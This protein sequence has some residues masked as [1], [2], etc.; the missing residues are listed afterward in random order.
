MSATNSRRLLMLIVVMAMAAALVVAGCGGSG[1]TTSAEQSPPSNETPE[2]EAVEGETESGPEEGEG[3]SEGGME[4][5][6]S[7]EGG[8]E[9]EAGGGGAAAEGKEV[10]AANCGSCHTLAAAGTSGNIGPNLDELMPD[11]S[12]VEMQVEN[13]GGAMPAFGKEGILSPEEV[14]AVSA[15]VS[16]EAGR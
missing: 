2:S 16:S 13:G 9:A 6:E 15:Y 12:T 14:K 10:F 5:E 3:M 7:M 4:G 11:E 1:G 8:A